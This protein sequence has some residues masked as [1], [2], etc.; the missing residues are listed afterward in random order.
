MS[1]M[2]VISKSYAEAAPELFCEKGVLENFAKSTFL[3]K[4]CFP[5][6]FAKFLRTFF[7]R[8][9]L[10]EASAYFHKFTEIRTFCVSETFF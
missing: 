8:T 9:P 1:P 10:V 7:Y 2:G 3:K 4:K 6:N 5:V